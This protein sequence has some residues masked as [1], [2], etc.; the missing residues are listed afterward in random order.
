VGKSSRSFKKSRKKGS[1]FTQFM[2]LFAV[3]YGVPFEYDPK[4]SEANKAKH[5]IDFEKAQP[6]WSDE[7]AVEAKAISRTEPRSLRVAMLNGKLWSAFF[8]I[9]NDNIRI[10][11]VRRARRNEERL[12][13]ES[14]DS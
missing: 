14:A 12:Y 10:I 11:S 2:T 8:T 13:D 6:L 3:Y 1:L 5:G 4:K 9:R 7:K